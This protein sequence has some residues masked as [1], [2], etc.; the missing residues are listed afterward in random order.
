MDYNLNVFLFVSRAINGYIPSVFSN[1]NQPGQGLFGR[2]GGGGQQ[3]QQQQQHQQQQQQQP[4][5]QQQQAHMQAGHPGINQVTA[6]M[7]GHGGHRRLPATPN[8]PST[9]F[10]QTASMAF[11]NFSNQFTKPQSLTFR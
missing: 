11:H 2:F 6:Q 4:Q 3:Q 5:H 10:T 8:K 9:L 7:G 1:F